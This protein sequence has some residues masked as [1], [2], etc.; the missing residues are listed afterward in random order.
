MVGL[1]L[2]QPFQGVALLALVV[3][4]AAHLVEE[5][6]GAVVLAAAAQDQQVLEMAS[7]VLQIPEEVEVV[8][9]H[10]LVQVVLAARAAPASSS[11]PTP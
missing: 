6:Q 3:V 7:P 5:R 4:V 9:A 11:C 10:L 8:L 2:R 1:V